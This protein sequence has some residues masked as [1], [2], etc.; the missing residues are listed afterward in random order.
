VKEP[1]AKSTTQA[2]RQPE[3]RILIRGLHAIDTL[4]ARI[5]HNLTVIAPQQ[6]P[7]RGPAILVCNHISSLDPVLLQAVCTTRVVTWMMAKEYMTLPVL[8]MVFRT[9]GVIPVERSGRDTGPLRTALRDLGK[10]RVV[11]IFPEGTFSTDGNLRKF[12]TGVALMAIKTGAAVYPAYQDG[13]HR[14][15]D[16]LR[17]FVDRARAV[18][19]FGP[20]VEFDRTN[21][22]RE[23][24]A[25]ATARIREAIEGLSTPVHEQLQSDKFNSVN[26]LTQRIF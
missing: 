11:G 6:L 9:L 2:D 22:S 25:A 1:S 7:R 3:D 5:Y 13:S 23:N 19:A 16:M 20:P 4:Y 26:K 21:S 15:S 17:A 18:V 14:N 12:H 10:G 8:G 24:L